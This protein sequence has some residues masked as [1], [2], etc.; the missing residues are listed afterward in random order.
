M[1]KLFESEVHVAPPSGDDSDRNVT[2]GTS[3]VG[4]VAL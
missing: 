1:R 3:E 2:D 4:A